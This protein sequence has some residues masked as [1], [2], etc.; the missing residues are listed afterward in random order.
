MIGQMKEL[1]SFLRTDRTK[2]KPT[3]W[4]APEDVASTLEVA[5]RLRPTAEGLQVNDLFTNDY[6]PRQ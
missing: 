6:L 3:L 1:A 5:K 4:L 2:G